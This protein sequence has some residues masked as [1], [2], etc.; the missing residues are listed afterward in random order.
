MRL[1]HFAYRN[2]AN[3]V[4]FRL[5]CENCSRPEHKITLGSADKDW[6]RLWS[7]HCHA[8][9]HYEQQETL[10][11]TSMGFNSISLPIRGHGD[12]VKE[13]LNSNPP[14]STCQGLLFFQASHANH[15]NSRQ[16]RCL[17]VSSRRRRQI[18]NSETLPLSLFSASACRFF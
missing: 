3:W 12:A 13:G 15:A 6:E 5:T 4:T 14:P 16:E 8:I 1:V 18:L 9:N 7:C 10:S 17:I 2:T 11:G